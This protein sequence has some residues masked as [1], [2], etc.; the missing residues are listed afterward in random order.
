MG[1]NVIHG[2]KLS[3][4]SL[5]RSRPRHKPPNVLSKE[6][7]KEILEALTNL[8]HRTM[9]SLIYACGLR[10]S[11]LLNLGTER[12]QT[13]P[14]HHNRCQ[15]HKDRVALILEKVIEMLMEYYRVNKPNQ[16]LFDGQFPD[17]Q[18]S[19]RFNANSSSK[20]RIKISCNLI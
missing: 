2:A 16:W 10:R 17:T 3:P 13:C 1:F 4:D 11:K 15:G 12:F 19:V 8:K 9:L 6:D 5:Q 14:S 18:Y 20:A 7:V